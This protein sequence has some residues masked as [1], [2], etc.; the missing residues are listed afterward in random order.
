MDMWHCV[1]VCVG[2]GAQEG[3][4]SLQDLQRGLE[5]LNRNSLRVQTELL[6]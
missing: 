4:D 2:K 3:G 6:H 5:I 1:C